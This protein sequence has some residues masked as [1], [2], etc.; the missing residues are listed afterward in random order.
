LIQFRSV[1]IIFSAAWAIDM[2]DLAHFIQNW[3]DLPVVNRTALSGFFAVN[4]ER[5]TASGRRAG[6]ADAPALATS[7][8]LSSRQSLRSW[9]NS[10][11]N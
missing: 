9:R 2:D 11:S 6:R 1:A 7:P 10:A 4:T 8:P 5:W 3:T